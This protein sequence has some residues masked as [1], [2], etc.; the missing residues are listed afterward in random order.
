MKQKYLL[1]IAIPVILIALLAV[2]PDVVP[3]HAQDEDE[4]GIADCAGGFSAFL[5]SAVSFLDS[6]RT[7]DEIFEL[8]S[9]YR[10][11]LDGIHNQLRKVRAQLR[12]SYLRCDL[13]NTERLIQSYYKIDAEQ[14][15][16]RNA[17]DTRF[18][19][20]IDN[21][22]TEQKS[23]N[24][25]KEMQKSYEGKIDS[26][27]MDSYMREFRAKY[28]SRFAA[29][30]SCRTFQSLNELS[31]KLEE[32]Q[33]ALE[34]LTDALTTDSGESREEA[35]QAARKKAGRTPTQAGPRDGPIISLDEAFNVNLK[36]ARLKIEPERG[37]EELISDLKFTTGRTPPIGKTNVLIKNEQRRV[38]EELAQAEMI[39]RYRV[40]YGDIADSGAAELF[41]TL[42]ELTEDLIPKSIPSMRAVQACTAKIGSRQCSQRQ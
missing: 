19:R 8:N 6:A 5:G 30:E 29:Y 12:S 2:V 36:I 39:A 23:L 27:L 4:R 37:M 25:A 41:A 38:S 32:L 21:F 28:R 13:A 9:C 18:G 42:D 40:L 35:R 11:D 3:A 1:Q 17:V 16:L 7:W 31:D 34:P 26:Q 14:W 20:V 22:T 24:L 15:F 33:E 10:A